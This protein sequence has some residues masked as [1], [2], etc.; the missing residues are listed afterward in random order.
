MLL[1]KQNGSK[2][3]KRKCKMLELKEIRK[4]Y[5]TGDEK[6][7]EEQYISKV[8]DSL[9]TNDLKSF[10]NHLEENYNEIEEDVS[11]V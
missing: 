2:L 6:V 11:S 8:L 1:L 3:N 5:S 4:T 9:S 10:K 7:E